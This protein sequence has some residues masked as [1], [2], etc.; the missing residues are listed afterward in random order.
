MAARAIWRGVVSFGVCSV[1]VKLY[2]AIRSPRIDFHLLHDTDHERLRQRLVCALDGEPVE[3]EQI[4]KGFP[5]DDDRYVLVDP[6]ELEALE[7]ESSRTIE[8]LD[9]V[10]SAAID[11]RFYERPYFLGPDGE[12]GPFAS[13]AEALAASGRA[14]ICC[15]VMRKRTFLGALGCCGGIL[16]LVIL[17]RAEEVIPAK[18]L[19]VPD[20]Q[21]SERELKTAEYLMEALAAGFKPRAFKNV[22]R[23]EVRELVARKARGGTV[24]PKPVR[25]PKPTAPDGLL[26]AL[27][28]SLKQAR[29]GE[30]HAAG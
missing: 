3:R 8:V 14:G 16:C 4:V 30:L 1:P 25:L 20:A 2:T 15:W 26:A 23:D 13:L 27:E 17:R 22:F 7:P 10:D 28:A 18:T 6:G 21:V 5:L 24:K 29:R 19:G 9:C 12:D 11:P